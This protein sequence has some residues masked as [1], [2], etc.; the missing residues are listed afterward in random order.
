MDTV[1]EVTYRCGH[2]GA[3]TFWEPDDQDRDRH[4]DYDRA[5][6]QAGAKEEAAAKWCPVCAE[7][8]AHVPHFRYHLLPGNTYEFECYHNGYYWRD[9]LRD[10]GY[11]WHNRDKTWVKALAGKAAAQEEAKFVKNCHGKLGLS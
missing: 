3:D 9:V 11:R 7:R 4:P 6:Y 10:A 5:A 8:Y 2:T 1:I